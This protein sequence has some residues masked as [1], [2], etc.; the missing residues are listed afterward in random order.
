MYSD[1]KFRFYSPE[2]LIIDSIDSRLVNKEKKLRRYIMENIIDKKEP[3]NL[4]EDIEEL[5]FKNNL[6]KKEVENIYENLIIKD[7]I[8]PDEEKNINFI[9]PVSAL[10]TNHKVTLED[11]RTFTAMCAIDSIGSH[12]T[13]K[14]NIEINSNCSNTGE[15]IYIKLEDGEIV[16]Y[17]P[18][19]L[20]ILHV[21]LNNNNDWSAD[22]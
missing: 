19:E 3:Y 10:A 8:V 22:C 16:D 7:I 2:E 11:G 13:F 1:L 6:G 20:H 4:L 15:E 14:Q 17:Y 18:E 5:S 21:D 9:Y 12:F